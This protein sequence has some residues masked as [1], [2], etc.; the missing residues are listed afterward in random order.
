MLPLCHRGPSDYWDKQLVDLLEFGFPLDFDRNFELQ[1]TEENHASGRDHAYDIEC[2]IQEKLKHEAMLGPFDYKPIPLHI[3]PFMT[4]EKPDSEVRRTIV[5]LSWP[6]NF[7][8]NAGVMKDKY[9]GSSF[10]LNYPSVDDIVKTIVELGPGSL[11]Y[12]V[13]ISRAFR[14]LKVNPGDLDLLGLKHQSYFIDQSVP[15]GYRH[16][17]VFFEKVTDSIRY[18]MRQ[19]GF[20]HL[21]NYVDDLIY[22][23]LPSNIH[24]SFET[25]LELL[26]QLG[27]TINPKKLVAPSTSL[28][29]LGILINT[30]TRAMSVPPDKLDSII[31]MCSQW[32]NKKFCSKRQLQSLLGSLLYVSKC[33]KPART[34][35]NR[36]LMLLR[37]NFEKDTIFLNREFF[38]DLNWFH[39]FLSQFT[40]VVYY[41]IRPVQGELHLDASLTGMGGIFDNQCYALPIQKKL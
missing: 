34:F 7:S 10:V 24:Q 9:L 40:G 3:S 31:D 17:S 38:K 11:L 41:D 27:L 22:C 35:L 16:G 26:T 1:S 32:Q 8:V 15:F 6:K 19:Q 36:M 2:Y 29:C 21:Y 25:L 18:I 28:I 39:T 5:D 20:P 37:E 12:K 23:G 14:Q 13:D 30:E 33:V 4:R